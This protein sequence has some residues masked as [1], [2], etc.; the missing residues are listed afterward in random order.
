MMW[1]PSNTV[2]VADDVDVANDVDV[3]IDVANDVE[4]QQYSECGR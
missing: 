1:N 2:D 4:S 3:A